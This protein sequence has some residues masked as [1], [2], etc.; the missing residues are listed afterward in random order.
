[1]INKKIGPNVMI[2]V[3]ILIIIISNIYAYFYILHEDSL[4]EL[5][6]YTNAPN[7]SDLSLYLFFI[8]LFYFTLYFSFSRFP[9]WKNG[10]VLRLE[11][12]PIKNKSLLSNFLILVLIAYI[13]AILYSGIGMAGG[14]ELNNINPLLYVFVL[15]R[16]DYAAVIYVFFIGLNKKTKTIIALILISSLARGWL[17][18]VLFLTLV[19]LA[20]KGFTLRQIL[21]SAYGVIILSIILSFDL[22]MQLRFNYRIYGIQGVIE[23]SYSFQ[24]AVLTEF[25]HDFLMRFQQIYSVAYFFENINYFRELYDS[26]MIKPL[27]ADGVIPNKIHSY[28][29]NNT[30]ES[31][32]FLLAD[33]NRDLIYG[34]KTAFTSGLLPYFYLSPFSIIVVVIY[35][36]IC[37]SI[38]TFF[39]KYPVVKFI[40]FIYIIN[41]LSFGWMS[42]FSSFTVTLVI[43]FIMIVGMNGFRLYKN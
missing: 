41:L 39:K 9:G 7:S 36:S 15:F 4:N 10:P 35:F 37:V 34:R 5:Y 16:I 33:H 18:D 43:T 28:F 27:Y 30:G 42:A 6:H 1:M 38:A 29:S 32:G 19:L 20:Y 40:I 2:N 11:S 12:I 26:G 17:G 31:L 24:F 14:E 13:F 3:W 22:L 25:I 21:F 23:G 8:L